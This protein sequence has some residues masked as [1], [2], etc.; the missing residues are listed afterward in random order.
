[1]ARSILQRMRFRRKSLAQQVL[2]ADDRSTVQSMH[3]TP[4]AF[5][6]QPTSIAH[7]NNKTPK[8]GGD[9]RSRMA[10]ALR[11][12]HGLDPPPGNLS[13]I[14]EE[15]AAGQRIMRAGGEREREFA[16]STIMVS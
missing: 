15:D 16:E 1:M 11:Y 5:T 3:H 10:D 4:Q 14:D 9:T 13:Q 6:R 7:S 2:E 12:G 8:S